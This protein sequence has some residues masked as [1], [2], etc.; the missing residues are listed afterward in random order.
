MLKASARPYRRKQT[1]KINPQGAPI[2]CH[3]TSWHCA[4]VRDLNNIYGNRH[5][6][7]LNMLRDPLDGKVCV[8]I[9]YRENLAVT[10]IICV[11]Y[12][13][14]YILPCYCQTASIWRKNIS[15]RENNLI[16]LKLLILFPPTQMF[17]IVTLTDFRHF[18]WHDLHV[19]TLLFPFTIHYR[20]FSSSSSSILRV[21]L[22]SSEH[23]RFRPPESELSWTEA[24]HVA[25]VVLTISS[26]FIFF[27]VN[28]FP[29]PWV[30]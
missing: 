7:H 13:L 11:P 15:I 8:Q 16:K 20:F 23:S 3:F 5:N 27:V 4:L 18:L 17:N 1:Q 12:L 22:S 29:L 28:S 24:W 21:R 9:S 2:K 6:K 14:S 10:K 25:L 30:S 19:D 26:W